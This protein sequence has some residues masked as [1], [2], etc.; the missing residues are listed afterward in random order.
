MARSIKS[1]AITFGMVVIPVK[2][3]SA[4][5]SQDISFNRLHA[6]EDGSLSKVKN[7][8]W[9]EVEDVEVQTAELQRGYP[10]SKTS[11]IIVTDDD[12]E[13]LPLPSKDTIDL[14]TFVAED[15]VDP[16]YFEKSYWLEPEAIGVKPY[17]MLMRALEEKGK[18]GI[19]KITIRTREAL[20]C[21]RASDGKMML[22]TL[23][24]PDELR[25]L[26][27]PLPRVVATPAEL[28]MAEQ[29]I[30]A[31][32]EPFDPDKYHDQYREALT[33]MIAAKNEG[34]ELPVTAA[35]QAPQEVDLMSAFS[36]ML[37]AKKAEKKGAAA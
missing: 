10:T 7:K 27:T 14:S 22:S 21:L 5:V 19:A 25:D 17:F 15:E 11:F 36:A 2:L 9:C 3:Y 6:H 35:P 32:S 34:R 37:A 23:Y 16:V 12:L 8:L 33:E 29:L 13:T 30:E 1:C 28:A 20:C 4:T 26:D 24:W 18:V 31:F